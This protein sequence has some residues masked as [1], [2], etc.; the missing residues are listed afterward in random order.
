MAAQT[1]QHRSR[2]RP[3]RRPRRNGW[4][5][6]GITLVGFAALT[7][8]IVWLDGTGGGST[9]LSGPAKVVDG[10]SL[11]IR[12]NRVRLLGIDAPELTQLCQRDATSWPCGRDSR[13]ALRQLVGNF[14]VQC[15]SHGQDRY[16]RLLATCVVNGVEINARLV[17]LGWATD[18]GGYSS[19]EGLARRNRVGIWAGQF[20]APEEWRRANRSQSDATPVIVH[21]WWKRL[22][23]RF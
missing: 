18:F 16:Q 3:R 1:A 13:S 5:G 20:E 12:G 9:A 2:G 19:E 21:S 23:A 4:G 8:I 11:E 22:W 15:Q 7:A 17:E 6:P 10:D 14:E